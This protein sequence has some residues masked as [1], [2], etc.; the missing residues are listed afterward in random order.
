MGHFGDHVN[1]K[2]DP[3]HAIQRI[4]HCVKKKDLSARDRK[5][6][7]A[8]V[9]NILR[10]PGDETT[11]NRTQPTPS[12]EYMSQTIVNI[13]EN[14]KWIERVPSAALKELNNLNM[15]HVKK[16]CLR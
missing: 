4:T 10:A 9:K 5:D 11:K 3:F 12:P 1:V 7:F 16:G 13:L 6:F 2:L 14:S 15:L 8:E